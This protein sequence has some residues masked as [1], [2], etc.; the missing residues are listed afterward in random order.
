LTLVAYLNAGHTIGLKTILQN[1]QENANKM[2]LV[3]A[4]NWYASVLIKRDYRKM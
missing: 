1:E 3:H 2:A 4:A